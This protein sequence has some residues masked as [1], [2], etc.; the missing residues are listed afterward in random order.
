MYHT[1]LIGGATPFSLLYTNSLALT[2]FLR[3]IVIISLSRHFPLGSRKIS[4]SISMTKLCL[5][6][7]NAKCVYVVSI[8]NLFLLGT[9]SSPRAPC[10]F[11]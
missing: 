11:C 8:D 7:I 5:L 4:F 9:K 1:L 2:H 6:H 10:Q 3:V